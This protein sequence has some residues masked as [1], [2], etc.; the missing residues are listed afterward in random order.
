MPSRALD[1]S[2]TAIR[3]IG[4][5]TPHPVCRGARAAFAS[6][7]PGVQP[8]QAVAYFATYYDLYWV[9]SEDNQKLLLRLPPSEFDDDR[10][11]DRLFSLIAH[12][13]SEDAT[14]TRMDQE[15]RFDPDLWIV[16][17]EDREGRAFIEIAPEPKD[18]RFTTR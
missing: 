13:V 17:I 5:P 8:T 11:T 14:R 15:M 3:R 9:L 4:R 2:R 6:P 12:E 10:P 18:R 7:P 1:P 16:D